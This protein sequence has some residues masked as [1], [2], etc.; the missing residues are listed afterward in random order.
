VDV[1]PSAL[2]LGEFA[3]CDSRPATAVS[4]SQSARAWTPGTWT[5]G[6]PQSWPPPDNQPFSGFA[7][8]TEWQQLSALS[9]R[10]GK[11]NQRQAAREVQWEAELAERRQRN[12]AVY[13]TPRRHE[14]A[15]RVTHT[16]GM[17]ARERGRRHGVR[18]AMQQK[19]D[20][21]RREQSALR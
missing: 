9:M 19:L 5:T 7:R 3:P 6:P 1:Q 8:S 16:H 14:F 17:S 20:T 10:W 15:P 12:S 4:V 21:A 18:T 13:R 2:A 11:L